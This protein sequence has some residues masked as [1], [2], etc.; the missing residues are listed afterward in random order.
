ME[1]FWAKPHQI[2]LPLFINSLLSFFKQNDVIRIALEAGTRLC[3]RKGV[4]VNT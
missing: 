2:I 1:A 3:L 4:H